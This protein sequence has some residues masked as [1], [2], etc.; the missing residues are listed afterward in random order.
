MEWLDGMEAA[1]AH[2]GGIPKTVLMDNAKPL[3]DT[4]RK[5]DAPA[6]FN[7]RLQAFCTLPGFHR[8]SLSTVSGADETRCDRARSHLNHR[9]FRCRVTPGRARTFSLSVSVERE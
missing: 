4:S 2:F 6:V 7:A 8:M 1:F 5:D 9:Q 3:I